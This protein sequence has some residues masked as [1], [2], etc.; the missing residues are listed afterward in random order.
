MNKCDTSIY[1]SDRMPLAFSRKNLKSHKN[2]L[3]ERLFQPANIAQI[4]AEKL[5]TNGEVLSKI[6][7]FYYKKHNVFLLQNTQMHASI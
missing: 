5:P 6:H 3:S 7:E 2:I 1:F 4:F